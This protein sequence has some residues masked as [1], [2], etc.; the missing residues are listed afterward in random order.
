MSNR[1]VT[2]VTDAWQLLFLS[3]SI[4]QVCNIQLASS[5]QI[6]RSDVFYH[7]VFYIFVQILCILLFIFVLQIVHIIFSVFPFWC[8]SYQSMFGNLA[9]AETC[10]HFFVKNLVNKIHCSILLQSIWLKIVAILLT[11]PFSS[12]TPCTNDLQWK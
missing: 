5:V 6:V 10:N 2:C 7:F 11:T 8:F 1:F 4:S 9:S 12:D 3:W